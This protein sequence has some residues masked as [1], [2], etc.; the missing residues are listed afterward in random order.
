MLSFYYS[1]IALQL[2]L[3]GLPEGSM[4]NIVSFGTR[5]SS[6]WPKSV[7]YDD[8]HLAAATKHIQF[9]SANMME[10]NLVGP[11]EQIFATEPQPNYDRQLFIL[12]DG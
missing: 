4:F 7:P 12:T 10:T 8:T 6:L 2:F 3:R 1:T 11:L 9:M 5:H